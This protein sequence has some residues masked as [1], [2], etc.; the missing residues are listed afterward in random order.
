MKVL[1]VSG[2]GAPEVLPDSQRMQA[3]QTLEA[4]VLKA[5]AFITADELHARV[6]GNTSIRRFIEGQ[7]DIMT[8]GDGWGDGRVDLVE[9]RS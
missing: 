4:R 6:R 2:Y 3:V 8:W 7:Q 1:V 9:V 5:A